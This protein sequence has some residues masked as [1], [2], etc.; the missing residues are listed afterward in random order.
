MREA[1]RVESETRARRRV[2]VI[3]AASLIAP[4]IHRFF[5]GRPLYAAGSLL[6][7]FLA[8]TLSLGGPWTFELPPLAPSREVLP[9]R[10][11]LAFAALLLWLFA[12]YR[13]WRP[14]RES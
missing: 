4:G 5:A 9:A 10:L 11:A 2:G 8:M 13:A 14:A 7:F 1:D 12:N 3:R 6:L